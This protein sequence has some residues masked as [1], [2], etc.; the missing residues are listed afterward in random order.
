[1]VLLP[2][3]HSMNA[4][5]FMATLHGRQRR[6]LANNLPRGTR[7]A[8]GLLTRLPSDIWLHI[9]PH[10]SAPLQGLLAQRNATLERL[11]SL[12][13]AAAAQHAVADA[14]ADAAPTDEVNAA[15]RALQWPALLLLVLQS[16][17][18]GCQG[19]RVL[20]CPCLSDKWANPG[21]RG[22]SF[23]LG[24]LNLTFSGCLARDTQPPVLTSRL[25]SLARNG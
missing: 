19:S 10:D 3:S 4:K 6:S 15:S 21:G 17:R 13:A 8:A 14:A 12:R 22:C 7:L 11:L 18:Q 5:L 24:R 16:L 1:M 23:S 25:S 20:S 9:Y 2:D